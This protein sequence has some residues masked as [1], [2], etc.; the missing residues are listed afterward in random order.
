MITKRGRLRIGK[1]IIVTD[2]FREVV[3]VAAFEVVRRPRHALMLFLFD[4]CQMRRG[5]QSERDG[6]L[7]FTRMRLGSHSIFDGVLGE[8]LAGMHRRVFRR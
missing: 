8:F 5:S 2:V 3:K 4:D 7:T 6:L 1:L